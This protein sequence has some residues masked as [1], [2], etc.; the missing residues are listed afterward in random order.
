[1]V[2]PSAGAVAEGVVG[3]ITRGFLFA[4]LR[5]YTAFVEA[6]GAAEAA[7]LL[8]R[9]RALVRGAVGRFKGAEIRTEGDSFHVV[10]T[11]VSAAVQCGRYHGTHA[12]PRRPR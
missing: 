6:R 5:G 2:E 1:M 9:Y 12:D 8:L 3:A 10:F 7:D 11:A 4:D